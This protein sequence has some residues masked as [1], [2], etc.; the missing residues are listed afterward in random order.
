MDQFFKKESGGGDT[1][2]NREYFTGIQMWCV[3]LNAEGLDE[4]GTF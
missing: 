4:L 2:G 1:T 3:N